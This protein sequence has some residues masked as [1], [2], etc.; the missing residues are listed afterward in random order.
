MT[1]SFDSFTRYDGVLLVVKLIQDG[2]PLGN[3]INEMRN[4]YRLK[5]SSDFIHSVG[6]NAWKIPRTEEPGR[7]QFMGSQELDTT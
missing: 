6:T 5:P 2:S 7:L 3:P 1:T 4:W